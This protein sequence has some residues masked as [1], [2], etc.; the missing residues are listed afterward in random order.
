[1]IET[2]QVPDSV[3][4]THA[5]NKEKNLSPHVYWLSGLTG[6]ENSGAAMKPALEEE[7]K[8]T[9]SVDDG[10][11]EERVTYLHSVASSQKTETTPNSPENRYI[12]YAKEI[13]ERLENNQETTIVAHSFGAQEF[14]VL[15][16]E[17]EKHESF[18]EHL[19]KLTLVLLAPYGVIE[20]T[21]QLPRLLRFV[22]IVRA[23][24]PIGP[25]NSFRQ[26]LESLS[27]LPP[28][29]IDESTLEESMR[30]LFADASQYEQLPEQNEVATFRTIRR[31]EGFFT[32]LPPERQEEIKA[33]IT[34][35]DEQM[36]TAIKKKNWFIY[37]HLLRRRGKLLRKEM[38][39]A[40]K[41]GIEIPEQGLGE[42]YK[43]MAQA[44]LGL[45]GMYNATLNGEAFQHIQSLTTPN[46][47]GKKVKIRAIIPEF[48][49]IYSVDE[50]QTLLKLSEE[51]VL[52]SI[53]VLSATTHNSMALNSRGLAE[54]VT[55]LIK[56]T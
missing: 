9:S 28:A 10:P 24:M 52:D 53:A 47:L 54:A 14:H 4:L 23:Q 22:E 38:E 42:M 8:K 35:I 13:V 48:D 2:Q 29:T 40:Y 39:E 1:M 7:L 44:Q 26:G 19:D 41:G 25:L 11:D 49:V 16:T 21:K 12:K 34:K 33:K 15:L 51:E 36:A 18:A 5:E 3:V 6:T 30:L 45:T 50:L 32:T 46:K 20:S 31:G 37:K 27:Y 56:N 17:L 55:H 43:T